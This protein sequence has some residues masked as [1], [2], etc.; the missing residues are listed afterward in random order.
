MDIGIEK[1]PY[2]FNAICSHPLKGE[3]AAIGT[4]DVKEKLHLTHNNQ[5]EISEKRI[6]LG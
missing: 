2:D 3:N 1:I 6:F 5:I 4:A